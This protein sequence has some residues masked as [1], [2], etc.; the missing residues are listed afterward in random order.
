MVFLNTKVRKWPPLVESIAVL[1]PDNDASVHLNHNLNGELKKLLLFSIV[2]NCNS[3]RI[4]LDHNHQ[5][6]LSNLRNDG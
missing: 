2:L 4:L 3:L 1:F 5:T 6:S